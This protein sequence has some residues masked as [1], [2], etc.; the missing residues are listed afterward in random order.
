M[1]IKEDPPLKNDCGKAVA[2]YD[3]T[4][5]KDA[6]INAETTHIVKL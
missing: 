1:L 5:K 6:V 3:Y 4:I 2:C